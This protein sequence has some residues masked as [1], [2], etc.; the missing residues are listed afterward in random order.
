MTKTLPIKDALGASHAM[1]MA[2]DAYGEFPKHLAS[3]SEDR[4]FATFSSFDTVN[5]WEVLQTGA[6]MTIGPVAG[7][8]A[9]G[10]SPYLPISSGVT[11]DAK[12]ILA[13]RGIFRA[14]VE[15]RVGLSASQRIANNTLRFGFLECDT[16]G[17]LITDTALIAA[18]ELLNARNGAML[19]FASNTATQAA[20]LCRQGGG[21]IDSVT[22]TFTNFTTAASGTAP[23]FLIIDVMSLSMERDRVTARSYDANNLTNSG[24][25]V[26][27]DM[28]IPNP[29]KFYRFVIVVEN[30]ATA[31]A[32]T[33]DWRLHF[34]NILD[35]TR[36]DVSPRHAGGNDASR[37]FPVNVLNTPAVTFSGT[38]AVTA[39]P[40]AGTEHALA[41]SAAT[42]NAT[43]VKTSAGNITSLMAYNRNAA[44]RY[45]KLYRKTSAPN[46]GTDVPAMVIPLLTGTVFNLDVGLLGLRWGTG[47]AYA[48]TAGEADNDTGAVAAGDV[49]LHMTYI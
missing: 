39:N 14:P 13:A 7:G 44:T 20:T 29:T 31:P 11:A 40:P 38:Q 49:K 22:T 18:P 21:G 2:E 12:T 23:N 16:T 17:A 35:A 42:T 8:A 36:F 37:G 19:D 47:I 5:D 6:G 33:T 15:V 43:S 4:F 3:T 27:R 32:T 10:A 25:Q 24:V 48:I 46:V 30:G 9:A 45:L 28:N 26:A 1:V 41:N 34:V